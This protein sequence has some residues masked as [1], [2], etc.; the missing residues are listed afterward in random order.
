M[1]GKKI[2]PGTQAKSFFRARTELAEISAAIRA[3]WSRQETAGFVRA[4]QS[5][6]SRNHLQGVQL[7]HATVFSPP[8]SCSPCSACQVPRPTATMSARPFA[9]MRSASSPVNM[10]PTTC[11]C[12]ADPAKAHAVGPAFWQSRAASTKPFQYIRKS[13]R[14]MAANCL[15]AWWQGP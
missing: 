15:H 8:V 14:G 10:L 4:G 9:G 6:P 3:Q 5:F 1:C 2:Y 11:V 13:S 12:L 7:L